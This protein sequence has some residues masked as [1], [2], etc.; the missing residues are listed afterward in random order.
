MLEYNKK[1]RTF[2][3]NKKREFVGAINIPTHLNSTRA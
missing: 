1:W 3:P 2:L